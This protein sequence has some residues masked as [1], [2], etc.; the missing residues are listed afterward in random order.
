M[1][2]Q[3]EQ[4]KPVPVATEPLRPFA[5]SIKTARGLLGGKSR[6]GIYE[7]AGRNE[8]DL[9]KDGAKTLVTTDSIARYNASRPRAKIKPIQRRKAR[10]Q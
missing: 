7:A 6:S 9:V 10:P 3:P 4:R 5:V 1:N 8:L 2:D